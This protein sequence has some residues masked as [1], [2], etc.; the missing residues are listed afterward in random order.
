MYKNIVK[1]DISFDFYI[2]EFDHH[3]TVSGSSTS[4]IPHIVIASMTTANMQGIKHHIPVQG[5]IQCVCVWGGGGGWRGGELTSQ[6][7]Q[8]PPQ[9][10]PI[11]TACS[12]NYH[13]E[14]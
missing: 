7:L 9:N 10:F 11:L 3:T 1:S 14:A 6:T 2:Q 5:S 4:K 13:R 8:L 12:A